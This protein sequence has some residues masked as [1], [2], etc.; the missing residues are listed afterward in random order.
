MIRLKKWGWVLLSCAA[1]TIV[2]SAQTFKTLASFDFFQT[3]ANPQYDS[4]VQGTDG[5]F[6]GTAPEG[7]VDGWGTVFKVTAGGDLTFLCNFGENPCYQESHPFA[8]LIQ[9][10]DGNFYGTTWQGGTNSAGAVFKT[11]AGG[12]VTLLYS[13][14]SQT[15]C[16]DGD[17]PF[18]PL[19]QAANGNF[20]GTTFDGGSQGYGT[21]YEITAAGTLTMLRSFRYADG[22]GPVAGLIQAKNGN[23]YGT[24]LYGGAKGGGTV[25]EITAGGK[26]TT[27]YSFC[28]RTHCADGANPYLGL[29]QAANG[30]F[31]G[32]TWQGGAHG[33]GTVFEITA[34]GKL[35]TLYSFCSQ[36][37]CTDGA[38]PYAGVIQA[39]DG[40]FYGTTSK[41]G[42]SNW[43][44]VY[45]IT[46]GG[47]LT[48]LHSFCAQKNCTDG[49]DPVGG[50][51][52]AKDGNFYGTTAE[53]GVYENG[54][55]FSASL[56]APQVK[57]P[58]A[59]GEVTMS[60]IAPGKNLR[61]STGFPFHWRQMS[62]DPLAEAPG[63]VNPN[64]TCSPTPCVLPPTQASEGGGMVT[65]TPI[66]TNPLNQ[67]ELLLGSFDGNC[68]PSGLGFHLSRDGGSNWNRVLCMPFIYTKQH[69]Y[70]PL[71]EP[72]VGYDRNGTAYV[73]G[74]YFDN[75]ALGYGFIGFQKSTDGTHWSKPAVALRLPGLSF[76]FETAFAVDTSAGSPRVNSLYVS[77]VMW[78]HQGSNNQVMVS[79]SSDGGIT[80]TQAA[81]DPVQIYPAEDRFTRMAVG[82]DGTVYLTWIHCPGAGPDESCGDDTFH[83]MFSK[84]ADGGITWS[85]P[86]MMAK[87]QF[88]PSTLSNTKGER[89][90]DYPVIGVDNSN[91]AHAGDLYVAMYNW[92][93]THMC[94]QV[95]RSADGGNTWS[96]PVPVAPA[97]DTHDQFFPSLSVSPTGKVGVSW[98]DR[99]NDPANIDYQA[100]AAISTDGGRSFPN[101][102]LTKAFSNP[103]TNGS[104]GNWMGDYTGNTWAG[105]DFLAV[106]MDSSNGVDMQEVIGGMRLH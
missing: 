51:I 66:V 30:S 37:H 25:F 52:Q 35:T 26:L 16:A 38:S 9:A 78:S 99:R 19:V 15:N 90:Y 7:G 23:F 14:C 59:Y 87:A 104:G 17:D 8:G 92:T 100:F 32:T 22:A 70:V 80:W 82:K 20:Y 39:A 74:L 21:V 42:A 46:P 6:Y 56:S 53:G 75:D 85:R 3:G 64:L 43:G 33:R 84:S 61:P 83:V 54:T 95:I 45:A 57:T 1:T 76:P 63:P 29:V 81:V 91:G 49:A 68:Y 5:N 58:P 72:S 86:H 40:N 2:S 62:L 24:T 31:Y 67:K 44:T 88:A 34:G 96:K 97:S 27:L 89:V 48:T 106:W 13:F 94:V 41:G 65:D 93:G 103:D 36:T 55:V 73:A 98:L 105:P 4:L 71:D 60:D 50:L 69:V 10:T 28:S 79:H 102:Q 101:T 18:G 12:D 11:T 77:G 47:K